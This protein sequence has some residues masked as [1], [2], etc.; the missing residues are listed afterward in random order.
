V[1][2]IQIV[3]KEKVVWFFF[4]G[5]S[6]Q[7][8]YNSAKQCQNISKIIMIIIVYSLLC[9][10]YEVAIYKVYPC[11]PL[12]I[13]KKIEK[14]KT[15]K[16]DQKTPT[17]WC[18]FGRWRAFVTAHNSKQYQT[19]NQHDMT[20]EIIYYIFGC[21]ECIVEQSTNINTFPERVAKMPIEENE[22]NHR[23]IEDNLGGNVYL[24]TER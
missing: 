1:R 21:L 4:I 8:A 19:N 6:K 3:K 7:S 18:R 23:V 20:V 10:L 11:E 2:D 12:K 16:S 14:F 5:E 9:Y 24:D 13:K 22:W 17:F 15:I